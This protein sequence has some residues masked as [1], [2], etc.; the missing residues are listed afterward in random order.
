MRK[1]EFDLCRIVACIAVVAIH[2]VMLFWDFDPA[3]PIWRFW[4]F[5]SL[6]VRFGVPLFFMLSGALLLGRPTLDFRRHLRRLL[7][8]LLLYYLWTLLYRVLDLRFLHL[9]ATEPD[10]PG[11]VLSGYY[12]LWFLPAIALCYCAL[13][14]LHGLAYGEWENVRRGALLLACVVI[15]LSTLGAVPEKPA[16]LAALLLPYR[17]E[18]LR[19]LVYM[20]LGRLLA[21]RRLSGKALALLGLAALAALLCFAALNR[22]CAIAAGKAVDVYYG[23]LQ[24]PAALTACFVFALCRRLASRAAKHAGLLQGLSECSLGVYL[25]H[26]I[27]VDL[28]RSRHWDLAR[29]SAVWLFPLC[30]LSFLLLSF[31]AAWV[32]KKLPLLR[33]LV[34]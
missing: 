8:F 30:L 20:L 32:L 14:L 11:L 26:P 18:D 22:H 3:S 4:N 9:W 6:A 28:L 27:F 15:V 13:P 29:F 19:Y 33:R 21:E 34:S 24:L 16:W 1:A 25:T 12:H 17:L 5:L 31:A 7:H 23:Y 2:T 10:F